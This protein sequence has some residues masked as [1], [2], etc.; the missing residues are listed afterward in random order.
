MNGE[1][2]ETGTYDASIIPLQEQQ[3]PKRVL[4]DWF[5]ENGKG[6]FDE[7]GRPARIHVPMTSG[8]VS[9][10]REQ[11][12]N[13]KITPF[14][15]VSEP[16][17][18]WMPPDQFS[19]TENHLVSTRQK[20]TIP[21]L[22]QFFLW[23]QRR[24]KPTPVSKEPVTLHIHPRLESIL[25]TQVI[26]PSDVLQ[27]S[28]T[29]ES[30][31]MVALTPD[32]LASAAVKGQQIKNI[33]KNNRFIAKVLSEK[34]MVLY[35]K[36]TKDMNAR[37]IVVIHELFNQESSQDIALYVGRVIGDEIIFKRIALS[38]Q[39]P[40]YRIKWWT[41]KNEIEHEPNDPL[42]LHSFF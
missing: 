23:L 31:M 30:E 20:P 42:S 6:E 14:N 7:H 27:L 12:G 17:T 16:L 33:D 26:T 40:R 35:G 32:G 29:G 3:E 22:D 2:T 36:S 39:S 25:G 11:K 15:T 4:Q 37:S 18:F 1:S 21:G 9:W 5:N 13:A 38:G 10:W 24:S 34:K 41:G 28:I 19:D 8:W